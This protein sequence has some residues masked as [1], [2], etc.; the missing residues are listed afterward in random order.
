V[1][2]GIYVPN[3]GEFANPLGLLSLARDAESAGWD[4]FFVWDH[5]VLAKGVE[6]TDAWVALAA[7]A[8][9]T[10]KIRLGPMITP[11]AR[12]RP[13]KLARE[14][15]SLDHLSGG[16]AVLGVGLGDPA[17]LEYECFG[18]DPAA[19]TRAEKLDE[20][21]GII[22][23][24]WSGE[25]FQHRGKHYQVENI[26]FAPKPLQAPRVPIWVAGLWP[27]KAPMLR[28]ARWDGVFPLRT[29]PEGTDAR[30]WT[31][32]SMWLRP[33]D[34]AEIR[35]FVLGHR[36][37]SSDP[38]DVVASGATPAAD[39][40]E[41]AEVVGSF[42][43]VGATWWLEWLDDQR[44]SFEQMKERVRAGPPKV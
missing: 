37:N 29:L 11:V 5:L 4:G 2:F 35:S 38:F 34:L 32:S 33:A 36:T 23:G 43:D 40:D 14:V 28:A 10:Q 6:V 27:H 1:R 15:A 31:W 24:L 20:G 39:T 17:H 25:S 44:G 9:S 13:W 41:A 22:T 42:Q 7:V 16:R 21:L 8:A 30:S 3:F 18:E 19:R 26:A 12:R